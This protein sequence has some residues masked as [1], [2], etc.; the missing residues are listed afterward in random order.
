[1]ADF[2][3]AIT[4]KI[5]ILQE[6]SGRCPE[7]RCPEWTTG[8]MA[9]TTCDIGSSLDVRGRKGSRDAQTR[10]IWSLCPVPGTGPRRDRCGR[11]FSSAVARATAVMC[12]P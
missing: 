4:L 3:S 12:R 5:L 1:M 2:V 8:R 7:P 6:K 10:L 9:R 11:T